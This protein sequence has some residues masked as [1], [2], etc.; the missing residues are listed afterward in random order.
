MVRDDEILAN[1]TIYTPQ[2]QK[3]VLTIDIDRD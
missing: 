3:A 1:P 2:I